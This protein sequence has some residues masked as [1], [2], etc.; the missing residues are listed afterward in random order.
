M[1]ANGFYQLLREFEGLALQVRAFEG[2]AH[3]GKRI[4][5]HT[6]GV[7]V[8]RTLLVPLGFVRIRIHPDGWHAQV[9]HGQQPGGLCQ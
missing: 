4:L 1:P 9:F 7:Q 5:E 2:G 8:E 6:G 3:V